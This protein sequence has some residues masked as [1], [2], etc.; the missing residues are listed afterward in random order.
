MREQNDEEESTATP[1][2]VLVEDSNDCAE[3]SRKHAAKE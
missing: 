3:R 1:K 2:V